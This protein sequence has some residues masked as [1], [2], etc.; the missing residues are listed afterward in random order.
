MQKTLAF[1]S[2]NCIALWQSNRR[3][4]I[5]KLMKISV[6]SVVLALITAQVLVAKT[7]RA[8]DIREKRITFEIQQ[9]S[10][11]NALQK[12]QKQS[13]Y[14]V[15]YMSPKVAPYKDISVPLATRSVQET[16]ELILTKT[17]L[18]FRQE[19]KTIILTEK[20]G[21]VMIEKAE[22]LLLLRQIQGKV[23]DE[24]GEALPG[25]S[26]LI[27]GTQQG[28]ISDIN[29]NYQ[30]NLEK[31]NATLVFSFVGYLSQEVETGSRS[32]ID[33]SLKSDTKSLDEV[34][35][36]ALGMSKEKR[37][38]GFS[39][40]ELKGAEVSATQQL[41]PVNSLMGKV[42][43]VQIDQSASGPFGNSRI[44]IRGNST[45]SQNNQPIFVIDGI[46]IDNESVS[47]GRDFANDLTNLNSENFETVSI[48]KGS[49]AAALY[50][51]RAIN[52]VV[53]ITTKKGSKASG[54]GI[55]I[56]QNV[57][58][59]NPY[60]GPKF[61][62]EFGGGSVGAFFTDARDPNYQPNQM[63]TTKVF[64]VDPITNE[65]YIDPAINRENEN[66]GPRFANQ[67]V[68]NYDGTW[69]EYKAV[70][71]NFLDAF[72]NGALSTTSIAFSGAGDKTTY[73]FSATHDGQTGISV[74][75]KMQRE[76]FN[77]RITHQLAKWLST[78]F[79]GGY[80]TS[81]N[82][83]PQNLTWAPYTDTFAGDN[84]GVAFSWM[85][86]RNYDTKYWNQKSKYTSQA[87]GGAPKGTNPLET[88][89]VM[90]PEF[91]YNM[92][93]TI[94]TMES[95]NFLGR[96]ALNAKLGKWANFTVEGNMNNNYDKYENKALGHFSDFK[97]GSYTLNQSKKES[98]FVKGIL[99]FN[100]ISIVKDLSFSGF[101]GGEMYSSVSSF[102]QGSTSGG[103]MVPGN[104]FITNSVN[105]PVVSGGI[106][107]N[108]NI[109]SVYASADFDYKNQF[110]LATTWRGDWSSAL[111][112]KDG[113]GN[114]FYNYPSASLSWITSETFQLPQVI[115]FA[116]LRANIAALGKDTD[117]FVINPGYKFA[118]KVIGLPGEPTLAE[119]SSR[120]TLSPKLRPERKISKEIGLEMRFLKSRVGLD[121]TLYQ[122]NTYDQIVDIST[123]VETGISGVKINAGNIQNKGIEISL[124]GSPLR[125]KDF[126]WN[127][128]LT[129]SRNK[130]LIVSL[131]EGRTDFS[132][133][134]GAFDASSWAVVGKSYG[135]IRSTTQ[136][137]KFSDA[138]NPANPRNGMT[139]LAWRNDARAAFPQRSNKYQDIGDIN[140]RFRG[141]FSNDF[142][143]KSFA[144]S[145]LFDAKI[146]G[147]M[148]MSSIRSGTHTGVLPNTLFG[149]DADHGGITW[150]SKYDGITYDDGMII[151]GVF[152]TGQ[153][154][155]LP[156][157]S[158]ADVGG[159][160]FKEA[161]AAGLVEPT[162]A[163]Q[164]YYRYASSSTGVSDFW[165]LKSS[166][167]ALRQVMLSYNLPHSLAARMKV[168]GIS[169]SVIGRDLG[170]I[171][172]SLPYDFNPASLNS[173]LTSAVGEEGFLPMIRSFGG[174]VKIRL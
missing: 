146:G 101:A 9:S 96:F 71:N 6:F 23:T 2:R 127:S 12:L 52:G 105:S 97:G 122:D 84:W 66:W 70:P 44:V 18:T 116:K 65:P 50:G 169:I 144:L 55:D 46:I 98:K 172:N 40:T 174:S 5:S 29:G 91:W 77:L 41:N 3:A 53:L 126:T 124:D 104:Y 111:T 48:L 32:T 15:F 166:W 75:N 117:P 110:Y 1:A 42:A 132:L 129:F 170:Y 136:S 49:S 67:K 171:Y 158:T 139:V 100:S 4:Y 112:Y 123:P 137:L 34:V 58:I 162:H 147:D 79:S 17:P 125:T 69:T 134:G 19:G 131:A 128:R 83:N 37:S 160:T 57:M 156:N 35:V 145:V 64:P 81:D 133:G 38:L 148:A 106:N 11:K 16:L 173:N 152:A 33:L 86:P 94:A 164:F 89:K 121:V 141:G 107:Y 93:N 115:T 80:T 72:K 85:F 14:H 165:V 74:N 26:I 43:G 8:Q 118:G 87:F 109:N 63:W 151:D 82:T 30:L 10:L 130:N 113:T 102:A 142:S 114:N 60:K 76:N 140:A 68:R 54:I 56:S 25:V 143:Y 138:D 150:T 36:T 159:M 90:A 108:K 21:A 28:T 24:K 161:Y 95:R 119:F 45:L 51:S 61:Q 157:G 153:K 73:R 59:Y 39:V 120:T 78:D 168:N 135:T 88:N 154:V 103:L 20:Q 27:K 22:S 13:G 31:E 99:A 163:P 155:S 7:S 47:G 62:N 92:N 149:R 167:I